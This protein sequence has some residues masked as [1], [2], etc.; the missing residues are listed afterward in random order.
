[1]ACRPPRTIE[2][3]TQVALAALLALTPPLDII[4]LQEVCGYYVAFF[5]RDATGCG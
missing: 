5:T 3:C 1:M 4:A 2:A